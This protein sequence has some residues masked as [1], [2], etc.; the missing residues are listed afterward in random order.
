MIAFVEN[1]DSQ[2]IDIYEE[3]LLNA[4]RIGVV[5][6]GNSIPQRRIDVRMMHAVAVDAR[7]K[8]A[9][10]KRRWYRR[11]LSHVFDLKTIEKVEDVV[12]LMEIIVHYRRLSV[13]ILASSNFMTYQC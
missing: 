9:V 11:C 1:S 3:I 7:M 10:R 13:A 2:R 12:C 6:R 8:L 4:D 5:T